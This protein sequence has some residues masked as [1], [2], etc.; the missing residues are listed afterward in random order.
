LNQ[1]FHLVLRRKEEESRLKVAFVE[2]LPG[3][4]RALVFLTGKNNENTYPSDD[5]E[6]YTVFM[7][8]TPNPTTGFL[9]FVPKNKIIHTDLILNDAVKSIFLGGIIKL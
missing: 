9:M 2:Y 1:D 5:K 4:E 6:Y 7:L 8:T 3:E